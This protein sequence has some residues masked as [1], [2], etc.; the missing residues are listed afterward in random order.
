MPMKRAQS[1]Q[2]KQPSPDRA[3]RKHPVDD[4]TMEGAEL[5]IRSRPTL[6]ASLT[7]EDLAFI[8]AYDGPEIVGRGGSRRKKLQG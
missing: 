6:L 8:L 5:R 2:A 1:D 7:P 3:V 4:L